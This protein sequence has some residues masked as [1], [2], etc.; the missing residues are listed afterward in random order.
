MNLEETYKR[1]MSKSDIKSLSE[2][3]EKYKRSEMNDKLYNNIYNN[4]YRNYYNHVE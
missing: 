2:I 3:V 1:C 4:F